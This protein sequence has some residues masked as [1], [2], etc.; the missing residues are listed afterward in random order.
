MNRTCRWAYDP[1]IDG[2]QTECGETYLRQESAIFPIVAKDPT[3][4]WLCKREK[5]E[6]TDET[7]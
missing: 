4:C 6:K 2:W 3:V 7:E 5:E 1:E